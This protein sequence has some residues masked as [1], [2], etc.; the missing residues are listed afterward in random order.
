MEAPIEATQTSD[1]NNLQVINFESRKFKIMDPP[2]QFMGGKLS[3]SNLECFYYNKKW[4][5]F[6]LYIVCMNWL[7]LCFCLVNNNVSLCFIISIIVKYDIYF[8]V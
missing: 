7:T 3:K 4:K 6:V 2:P 5:F 8:V 1:T